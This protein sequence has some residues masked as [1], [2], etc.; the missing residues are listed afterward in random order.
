[1]RMRVV[2]GDDNR[3]RRFFFRRW[4]VLLRARIGSSKGP[5]DPHYRAN[6][7][8]LM[9]SK[10]LNAASRRPPSIKCPQGRF[11]RA[12]SMPSKFLQLLPTRVAEIS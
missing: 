11:A 8:D 1:M 10:I 2:A 5:A 4:V 12:N 7:P 9:F 6:K 3:A